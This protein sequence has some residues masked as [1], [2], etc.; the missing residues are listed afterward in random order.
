MTIVGIA[1]VMIFVVAIAALM[2]NRGGTPSTNTENLGT[3]GY[4][5]ITNNT[6]SGTIVDNYI[7]FDDN[8]TLHNDGG[9][10]G[11]LFYI[12]GSITTPTTTCTFG[13]TPKV[14]TVQVPAHGEVSV[15]VE[16]MYSGTWVSG[17]IYL[18]PS[19]IYAVVLKPIVFSAPPTDGAG[20]YFAYENYTTTVLIQ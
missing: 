5:R 3:I 16:D 1:V 11:Y 10:M 14:G 8:V 19:G 12:E 18:P 17:S 9:E 6:I 20:H 7:D 4:V 15:E 13:M 2:M